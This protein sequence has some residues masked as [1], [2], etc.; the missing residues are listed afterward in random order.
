MYVPVKQQPL[1][2]HGGIAS[3]LFP[4]FGHHGM[5]TTGDYTRLMDE[6]R[7]FMRRDLPLGL[8]IVMGEID[9]TVCREIQRS[10]AGMA[11]YLS[12]AKMGPV[13]YLAFKKELF[14]ELK[15]IWHD[16][17]VNSPGIYAGIAFSDGIDNPKTLCLAARLAL[18]MAL[19]RHTEFMVLDGDQALLAVTNF[20]MANS[21]RHDLYA[22][23]IG[24]A[25]HFQPQVRIS[26]GSPTGAEALARWNLDGEDIP[27]VRFIPIAEEAGLIGLLGEIMLRRSAQ[28]IGMLRGKGVP[29]PKIS[30]N[31]SP[32]QMF[33]GDFLRTALDVVNQ[34]GLS[35]ADI[36]LEITESLAGSS[37]R[38]F[39]LWM[40]EMAD[41]GFDLAIDDFGTGTS[42]LARVREFP[43]K[44]IKLDRSFVTSLPDDR[45]GREVCQAALHITHFLGMISLA[46][47]VETGGQAR[48]LNSVGCHLGQGY[49]WGRPMPIEQI[50]EWW[51]GRRHLD[52][53]TDVS[54]VTETYYS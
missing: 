39:L 21:M 37:G 18:Q 41:A 16:L 47:G 1:P 31:V 36:E 30:V 35:P 42:T 43:A 5:P 32:G 8:A 22:D 40:R 48:Y 9:S 27:P 53:P 2:L 24:F 49:F 3:D 4:H 23:G 45:S 50:P 38:E 26:S 19:A 29:I 46:E 12:W 52:I 20:H 25:A 15:P 6:M 34:E 10:I 17:L 7:A 28:A 44:K 14:E 11:D 51:N 54:A 33:H 13:V